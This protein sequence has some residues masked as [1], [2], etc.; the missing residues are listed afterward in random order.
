[1][2][3]KTV[4]VALSLVFLIFLGSP[5]V[6]KGSIGDAGADFLGLETSPR[7]SAMGGAG[8]ALPHGGVFNNPAAT[9]WM[10]RGTRL[11]Y[12][13]GIG[14]LKSYTGD[15]NQPLYNGMVGVGIR[16][17]GID[18][19]ERNQPVGGEP[20]FGSSFTNSSFSVGGYYSERNDNFS[21][22]GGLNIIND[23]LHDESATAVA[24]DAGV[25]Y[26][27]RDYPAR[28]GTTLKNL[29]TD[30]EYLD[31]SED[32]PTEL[33]IGGGWMIDEYYGIE[34]PLTLAFDLYQNLP[35]SWT[36]YSLGAEVD[37]GHGVHLRTGYSDIFGETVDSS[38]SFGIGL[39]VDQLTV[40]Y[41][42]RSG[43]KLDSQNI[44]AI[45]YEF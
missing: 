15:Y 4:V 17:H 43:D 37:I 18:D 27:L 21:W 35:E 24:L 10:S 5:A 42:H 11:S 39:K 14:D 9:S 3:S 28:F 45:G 8:V 33:R 22:G 23:S 31:K 44:F 30:L 25:Q 19:R 34:A 26:E 7:I 32:L 29:G 1:M 16:Y 2:Y 6:L 13:K 12:E 41:A 20:N 36:G 38:L 40:D